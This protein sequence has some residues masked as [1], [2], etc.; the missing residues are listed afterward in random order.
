M[1]D[2]GE[3]E[4]EEGRGVSQ[5]CEGL[6]SALP[7]ELRIPPGERSCTCALGQ[8]QLGKTLGQLCVFLAAGAD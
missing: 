5:F 2:L 6:A 7:L 1:G 4:I 3:R 8:F